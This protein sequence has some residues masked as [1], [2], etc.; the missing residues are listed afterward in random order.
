[1]IIIKIY[2]KTD[3]L[4]VD[5]IYSIYPPDDTFPVFK[6]MDKQRF[7]VHYV[8]ERKDIYNEYCLKIKNCLKIIPVNF[9]IYRMTHLSI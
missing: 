5:F 9:K 1:M 4:F 3:Y 2:K 7:P 6:E 8:T